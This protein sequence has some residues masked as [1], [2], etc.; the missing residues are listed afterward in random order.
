M[1]YGFSRFLINVSQTL[2]D[3]VYKSQMDLLS[4]Q[5]MTRIML[6]K[7]DFKSTVLAGNLI[8]VFVPDGQHKRGK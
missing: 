7:S 3:D 5:K 6:S 4:K 1:A 8:E 2:L